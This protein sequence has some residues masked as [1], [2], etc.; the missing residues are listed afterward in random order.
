MVA[1][2]LL[3]SFKYVLVGC[4]G[5]AMQMLRCFKGCY[6]IATG[7]IEVLSVF[8]VFLWCFKWLL[9]CYYAVSMMF[10]VVVKVLLCRC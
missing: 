3:C 2:M 5:V 10:W 1:I 8:R 6:G 9:S 4:Q 7:I